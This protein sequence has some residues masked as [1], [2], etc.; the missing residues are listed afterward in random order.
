MYQFWGQPGDIVV[1]FG[2]LALVAQGLQVRIPGMELTPL[3]K[4]P[5]GGIPNK[6]EED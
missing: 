5:Y 1:K 4:P 6:I 2:H 3:V